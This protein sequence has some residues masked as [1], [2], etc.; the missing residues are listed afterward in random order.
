M[1]PILLDCHPAPNRMICTMMSIARFQPA[2]CSAVRD[3]YTS[4][5]C[6]TTLFQRETICNGR[7]AFRPV[8]AG[9][10]MCRRQTLGCGSPGA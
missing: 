8:L 7:A 4:C 2:I 9:S 10:S 1:G 3:P 6:E 5:G